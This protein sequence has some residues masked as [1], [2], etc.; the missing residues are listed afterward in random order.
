MDLACFKSRNPLHQSKTGGR[1]AIKD[2]YTPYSESQ[3]RRELTLSREYFRRKLHT[4]SQHEDDK[5]VTNDFMA[6]L[7]K[8][9]GW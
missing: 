1:V 2:T 6:G 3:E 4:S 9:L 7:K 5:I 8:I